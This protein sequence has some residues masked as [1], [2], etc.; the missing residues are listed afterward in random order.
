LRAVYLLKIP[1]DFQN[2]RLG[3]IE[4]QASHRMKRVSP[5]RGKKND[6]AAIYGV[7]PGPYE[8]LVAAV[9]QFNGSA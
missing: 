6:N 8:I 5:W 4:V 1:D 2:G 7:L 9:D 3:P